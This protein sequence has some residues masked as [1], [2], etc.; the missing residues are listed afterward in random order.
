[1]F[2]NSL[3]RATSGRSFFTSRS[4]FVPMIFFKSHCIDSFV[5][6]S[7]KARKDYVA[8]ALFA[9]RAILRRMT[10]VFLEERSP[11]MPRMLMFFVLAAA[12]AAGIDGAAPST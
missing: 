6:E 12:L 2:S 1:M 10:W 3:T 4:F 11:F 8:P 9:S 5:L 7:K